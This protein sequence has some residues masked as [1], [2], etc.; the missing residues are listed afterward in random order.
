[1]GDELA[2]DEAI[3]PSYDAWFRAKVARSLE[4]NRDRAAMIPVEQVLRDLS[5]WSA[6]RP[7]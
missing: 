4:Q 7:A 3:E 2:N 6:G 5:S 1:M